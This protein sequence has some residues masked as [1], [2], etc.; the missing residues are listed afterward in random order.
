MLAGA[1]IRYVRGFALNTSE[2]DTTGGEIEYGVR[3]A[4]ALAAAG[5]P[6][7][8]FVINTAGNGAGFL[9]G[10]VPNPSNPPLCHTPSDAKCITLGIPP[11]THVAGSRWNLSG[12]DADLAY[13][14]VDAYLW[15]DRPWLSS[16]GALDR[17]RALALAASTPFP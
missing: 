7:K 4:Q 5:Y 14:H 12:Y 16:A 15:V 17:P 1:G 9:N 13:H 11:T 10:E 3:L 8:R 2:F 6:N